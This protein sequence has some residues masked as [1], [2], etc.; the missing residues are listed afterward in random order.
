MRWPLNGD[1]CSPPSPSPRRG[2]RLPNLLPKPVKRNRKKAI[3]PKQQNG[4][5]P[6]LW[7]AKEGLF[8]ER[9][10]TDPIEANGVYTLRA[11]EAQR[12]L[13]QEFGVEYVLTGDSS[14]LLAKSLES[15]DA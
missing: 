15:I 4:G 14:P 1:G 9:F 13:Q 12:I 11:K 10:L 6:N 5:P 3:V 2:G 8:K 7:P